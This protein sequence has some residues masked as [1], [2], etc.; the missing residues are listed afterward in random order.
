MVC[1]S[2]YFDQHHAELALTCVI[3]QIHIQEHSYTISIPKVLHWIHRM[4]RIVT[5]SD[6]QHRF[7]GTNFAG[8]RKWYM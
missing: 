2:M 8:G 5:P 1:S 4:I 3:D 6:K 7:S